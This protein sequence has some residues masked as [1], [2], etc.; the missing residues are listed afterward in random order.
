[1]R[2]IGCLRATILAALATLASAG[3][4][5]FGIVFD[6]EPP[7]GSTAG[8]TELHITGAG[9]AYVTQVLIGGKECQIFEPMTKDGELTCYSPALPQLRGRRSGHEVEV[10]F[11]SGHRAQWRGKLFRT[12]ERFTPFINYV[13]QQALPVM[14]NV[15]WSGDLLKELELNQQEIFL[16]TGEKRNAT[17]IMHAYLGTGIEVLADKGG[18]EEFRCDIIETPTRYDGVCEVAVGTPA[19][20]YNF[21]YVMQDGETGNGHGRNR[22]DVDGLPLVNLE[23]REYV[24][25]VFPTLQSLKTKKVGRLGGSLITLEAN[26][27]EIGKG[28]FAS[29]H[30]VLIDGVPCEVKDMLKRGNNQ[31]VSCL[32]GKLSERSPVWPKRLP[33]GSWATAWLRSERIGP[34]PGTFAIGTPSRSVQRAWQIS[35]RMELLHEKV[36]CNGARFGL[37][38]THS[39][40]ECADNCFWMNC[41]VFDFKREVGWC[42]WCLDL[43]D[44]QTDVLSTTSSRRRNFK[45]ASVGGVYRLATTMEKYLIDEV[46]QGPNWKILYANG[47]RCKGSV[48]YATATL[49]SGRLTG[50]S[51]Q[52]CADYCSAHRASVMANSIVCGS[53]TSSR[54]QHEAKLRLWNPPT[55]TDDAYDKSRK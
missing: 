7:H 28:D 21:T 3:V 20:Y 5:G 2:L 54:N 6:V 11:T 29:R 43:N 46:K 37:G 41:R 49:T 16:D 17:E 26:A 4:K 50:A 51:V 27:L 53:V 36:Q 9:F 13:R 45:T 30:E 22:W 18:R 23:G 31:S 12:Y 15:S 42:T 24:L 1:M 34:G 47:L 48:H 52:Q 39:L 33:L 8:G 40:Q 10:W 35:D 25:E 14:N 32:A 55:P 44:D 19:G 38:T